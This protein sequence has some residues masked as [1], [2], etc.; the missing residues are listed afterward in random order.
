MSQK[1]LNDLQKSILRKRISEALE[2]Q[3]RINS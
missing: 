1:E 2:E 3:E